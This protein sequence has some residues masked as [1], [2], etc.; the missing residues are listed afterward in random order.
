[1]L[2]HLVDLSAN[3]T[4]D[5]DAEVV[6]NELER[7]SELLTKKPRIVCGSKL[8]S[9]VPDNSGKLR[10]YAAKN[11]YDYFEISAVTGDHVRELVRKLARFVRENRV[12]EDVVEPVVP[13]I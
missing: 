11:G 12:V 3:E 4:P 5:V 9:A 13:A 8:D 10:A 7:Y 6:A 2:V 1:M